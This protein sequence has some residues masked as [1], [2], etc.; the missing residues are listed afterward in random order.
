LF[1]MKNQ[2][3]SYAWG[4]RTSIATMTGEPTPSAEPQAE[5][6]IGAH[7]G[8]SSSLC[9][10]IGEQPLLKAIELD[11]GGTL[12]P[13]VA[14]RFDGGLPFLLKLLAADSP[15][16]LQAHPSM[17]QARVGF[18]AEEAAGI[19]LTADIRNYK[20]CSHK[21]EMIYALTAFEALCG[22]RR[23]SETVRLL[24]ELAAPQLA[25]IHATLVTMQDSDGLRQVVTTL[26]HADRAQVAPIVEAVTA[27]ARLRLKDDS[28]FVN[29]FAMAVRLADQYPGDP[30][31]LIALLMN[32]IQLA[33][34]E[35]VYLPAGN[36]HAYL[37]GFGVEI[38]ASSDNVL[39]GGL[40][41]K[42]VDIAELSAVVCFEPGQPRVITPV[43]VA[44]GELIY[45]TPSPEFELS[46]IQ[47]TPEGRILEYGGPQILLAIDGSPRLT[48]AQGRCVI[49]RRGQSV[50]LPAR[51]GPIRVDGTGT[52][53][54]AR[55]GLIPTTMSTSLAATLSTPIE[56]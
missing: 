12:G 42:H 21:P 52:I 51:Q 47:A 39:R 32:K 35:A 19:P 53:V 23:I 34:G 33:P 49:M 31:V 18:D 27:L 30:G 5:L 24:D 54:R 16:S 48:D 46:V 25:G 45:R 9:S 8:G 3:R 15:L 1:L 26:L 37:S 43:P 10:D 41:T 29:E 20:D 6:W 4:S 56:S 7:P 38:M 22:F 14:R 11:P 50:F 17:A 44:P 28:E 2:I 40:T 13:D 36:M 55:D